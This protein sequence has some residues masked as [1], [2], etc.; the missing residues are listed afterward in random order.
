MK[1]VTEALFA[2]QDPAYRAF[3]ARL[4]P[5]VAWE[6][7]IG[8]RVPALRRYAA[9][10]AKTPQAA[11]FLRELPHDYYEENNLHA[12]LLMRRKDFD[13]VLS[14]LETFLP[15]VDN[16]ATCDLLRPAC[17]AA[18]KEELLPPVRRWLAS[19]HPY[20]VRFGIE[21]LMT[22]YLQTDF[23]PEY[24]AWVAAVQ[25]EHYYVRMMQAWYFATALAWHAALSHR[26]PPVPLGAHKDHSEGG[27][28]LPHL[29]AA[30][31]AAQ[32][33]SYCRQSR[34]T[35]A[36]PPSPQSAAAGRFSALFSAP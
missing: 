18:H 12:L 13:A 8:V 4:I 26:T 14:A 22:H 31:A 15:Q 25:S 24:P 7:V 33:P 23:S 16:W 35:P 1:Q 32:G 19:P 3:H 30:E 28:K 2:L 5:G 27:R 17:F 21:M 34:L 11:E 36:A 6:R 9:A 29:P 20:T 10:F